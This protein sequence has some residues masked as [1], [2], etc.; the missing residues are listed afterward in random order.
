MDIEVKI[1]QYR[2][3]NR[4]DSSSQEDVGAVGFTRTWLCRFDA[5]QLRGRHIIFRRHGVAFRGGDRIPILKSRNIRTI[6]VPARGD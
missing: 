3:G 5:D 2:T 4:L 6:G 1:T